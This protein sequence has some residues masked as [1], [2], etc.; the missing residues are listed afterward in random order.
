M[1]PQTH[2]GSPEIVQFREMVE[3]RIERKEPPLAAI[4]DD[5]RPLIVKLT[6]ER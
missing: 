2:S 1:W 3:S 5:H 4:P 6:Q